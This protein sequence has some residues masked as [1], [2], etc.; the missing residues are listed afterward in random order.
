MKA[1][2]FNFIDLKSL[3]MFLATVFGFIF[4]NI[5]KSD[6]AFIITISV[7]LT[8]LILNIIKIRKELKS[9]K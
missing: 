8:G 6:V 1:V 7:G 5:T 3:A 4:S 2:H 9:K